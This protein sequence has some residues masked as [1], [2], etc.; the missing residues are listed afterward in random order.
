MA[1]DNKL[2][3]ADIVLVASG[4]AALLGSFLPWI[5]VARFG[6][7]AWGE[8]FFPTYTWVGILGLALAGV[9]LARTFSTALPAGGVA[10][11]SWQQLYWIASG[12]ALVLSISFLIAGS[13]YGIGFFLSLLASVGMVVGTVLA[14]NE[15]TDVQRAS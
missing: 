2:G 12:A 7:N 13:N 6:R 14:S 11:F 3:T 9:V 8:G 15:T 4:G 5:S 10:G 1:A